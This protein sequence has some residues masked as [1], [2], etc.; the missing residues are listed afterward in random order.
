M[1]SAILSMT[2]ALVISMIAAAMSIAL[3]AAIAA[4]ALSMAVVIIIMIAALEAIHQSNSI[5]LKPFQKSTQIYSYLH[6]HSPDCRRSCCCLHGRRGYC[7]CGCHPLEKE[8]NVM[9][10]CEFTE[11]PLSSNA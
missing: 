8:F 5:K 1:I 10:Q 3:I 11:V 7:C 9:I 4:A 2:A 6:V